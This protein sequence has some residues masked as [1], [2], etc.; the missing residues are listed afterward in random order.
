MSVIRHRGF[1]GDL[2]DAVS[3][4]I[5]R[6]FTDAKKILLYSQHDKSLEGY[7]GLV[8]ALKRLQSNTAGTQ[9]PQS[10]ILVFPGSCAEFFRNVIYTYAAR[11]EGKASCGA[12]IGVMGARRS[13]PPQL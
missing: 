9:K 7:K 2:I 1:A 6:L 12:I 4:R 11:C 8:R 10:L 13:A 5:S 3:Y